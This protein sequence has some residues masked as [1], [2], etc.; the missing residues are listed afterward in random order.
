M[1]P[2]CEIENMLALGTREGRKPRRV[3]AKIEC[4]PRELSP[5]VGFIV[6]IRTLHNERVLA[7][8]NDPGTANVRGSMSPH[9]TTRTFSPERF[10]V[11][12]PPDNRP[13]PRRSSSTQVTPSLCPTNRKTLPAAVTFA[14]RITS[15]PWRQ[16][17]LVARPQR[18]GW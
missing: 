10:Y 11:R 14:G 9:G 18:V 17:Q 15:G 7:F 8:Y 3:V 4:H 6:T 5:R 12:T 1:L 13:P 2:T 16:D